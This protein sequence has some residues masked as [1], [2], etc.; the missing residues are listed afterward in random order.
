[1]L[2]Y[3]SEVLIIRF[4]FRLIFF[5]LRQDRVELDVQ[6]IRFRPVKLDR[7]EL[8]VLVL[9]DV[10]QEKPDFLKGAFRVPYQKK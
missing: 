7:V 9:F 8:R 5:Q 10:V 6:I 3:R 2:E 4:F 1:M